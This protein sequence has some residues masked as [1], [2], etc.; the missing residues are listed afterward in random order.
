M[1]LN[2]WSRQMALYVFLAAMF[3]APKTSAIVGGELCE[4]SDHSSAVAIFTFTS[5]GA[6]G[7]K[8]GGTLVAPDVVLTA[9]HCI[10]G[11]PRVDMFVSSEDDLRAQTIIDSG[12]DASVFG[13]KVI[14]SLVMPDWK[15]RHH[16]VGLLFLAE[17]MNKKP[18]VMATFEDTASLTEGRKVEFVGW[19]LTAPDSET[20]AGAQKGCGINQLTREPAFT[21]T[22]HILTTEFY[23]DAE[24]PCAGDSGG[25]LY[26]NISVDG[27]LEERLI[28]VV[29]FGENE[30]CDG[31]AGYMSVG[32]LRPII[33]EHLRKGCDKG[34]RE[35]S[36]G[37]TTATSATFIDE[38]NPYPQNAS[39]YEDR[40]GGC[41]SAGQTPMML[42][43]ILFGFL[44]RC[45]RR[46]YGR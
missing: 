8:C 37:Q 11:I 4:P 2:G 15:E 35:C 17:A 39:T 30:T 1:S 6:Y 12:G 9:A 7:V 20:S 33:D 46:Q 42:I 28:G 18:A 31:H 19:G 43:C 5:D 26:A 41:S 21:T 40:K 24:G 23:P 36:N 27:V 10:E 13:T 3:S 14:D 44:D 34:L 38:E 16:D 22:P 45:R 29:S 32:R 25:P